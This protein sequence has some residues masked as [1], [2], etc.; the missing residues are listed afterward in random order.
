MNIGISCPVRV[1]CVYSWA[2]AEASPDRLVE[3]QA[4]FT[5]V[6]E[7]VQLHPPPP[8]RWLETSTLPLTRSA[9]W[10]RGL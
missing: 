8:L 4:L 3:A 9:P 2:D 1:C 10:R 7:D 6:F 5:S